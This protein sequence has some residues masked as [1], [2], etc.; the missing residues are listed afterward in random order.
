MRLVQHLVLELLGRRST[1]GD[2][3]G[4]DD[5]AR[6]NGSSGYGSGGTENGDRSGEL[7]QTGAGGAATLTGL[8]ALLLA[9]GCAGMVIPHRHAR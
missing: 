7:A 9:A 3:S 6:D 1:G 5:G 8:A 2:G 4:N